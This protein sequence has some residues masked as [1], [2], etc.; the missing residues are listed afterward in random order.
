MHIITLLDFH[1]SAHFNEHIKI[2]H[3]RKSLKQYSPSGFHINCQSWKMI[4]LKMDKTHIDVHDSF[5]PDD[6]HCTHAK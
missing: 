1:L 6:A 4:S 5:T 3:E 2:Q